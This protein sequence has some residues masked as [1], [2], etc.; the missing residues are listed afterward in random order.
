MKPISSS[1]QVVLPAAYV[2][3]PSSQLVCAP[4][5]AQLRVYTAGVWH[6]TATAAAAWLLLLAAPALLR[7]LYSSAGGVAVVGVAPGSGAGGGA[8]LQPGDVITAV[9]VS[10]GWSRDLDTRL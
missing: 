3:L 6:N 5:W 7:P 8:G 9:Q 2:E 1:L 4:G 10:C